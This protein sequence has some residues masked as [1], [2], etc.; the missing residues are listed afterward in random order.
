VADQLKNNAG[1]GSSVT[2]RK[3]GG[4]DHRFRNHEKELEEIIT[5]WLVQ[6]ISH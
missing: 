3:I 1:T 2:V 5:E 4:A 6:Q